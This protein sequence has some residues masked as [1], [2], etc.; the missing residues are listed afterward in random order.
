MQKENKY[1]YLK[2]F[3]LICFVI[4]IV[5]AVCGI[6]LD[7]TIVGISLIGTLTFIL[8]IL[9]LI[10]SLISIKKEKNTLIKCLIAFS[11]LFVFFN[12]IFIIGDL[13]NKRYN[14]VETEKFLTDYIKYAEEELE[15]EIVLK[16]NVKR[17]N[18]DF[19]KENIISIEDFNNN[20]SKTELSSIK[21]LKENGYNCDGYVTIQFK[22]SIDNN[23]YLSTLNDEEFY[24]FESMGAYFDV[25]AYISC[26]GK[27]SQSSNGFDNSKL[28]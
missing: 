3:G 18:S 22:D 23:R 4:S 25:N 27:F 16:E 20:I 13:N 9:C 26:S 17:L 6:I 12:G 11:L 21:Q 2:Y 7:K 14:Y 15:E 1:L 10:C 5:V 19:T 24:D 28:Q 8:N